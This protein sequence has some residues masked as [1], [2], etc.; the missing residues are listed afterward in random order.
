MKL[1][2]NIIWIIFGGLISALIWLIAGLLFCITIIGIPFGVQCFKFAKLSLAPFGKKV[3]VA[4][5]KHPIAN[6]VW[7][8]FFG[9]EM[10]LV[11]LV[12]GLLC[13]IT[14]IGIP[15][16]IQAFKFSKL[17]L[18]PFGATVRSAKRAKK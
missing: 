15:V 11:Q 13:C 3:D 12:C 14:I 10:L 16:G 17:S 6:T 9:W 5:M 8:I 18:A 4:Y 7:V 2:A 1:I